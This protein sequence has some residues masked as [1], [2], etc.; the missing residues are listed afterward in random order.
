L[1]PFA[2]GKGKEQS[3]GGGEV[4]PQVKRGAA[5]AGQAETCMGGSLCRRMVVC[6]AAAS[7]EYT[8][9]GRGERVSKNDF[10]EKERRRI[11][12]IRNQK[13]FMV[14]AYCVRSP[15]GNRLVRICWLVLRDEQEGTS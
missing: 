4:G 5:R 9:K 15:L 12:V 10:H 3:K 11:S 1:A 8:S 2:L 14:D 6:L 13:Q 7:S